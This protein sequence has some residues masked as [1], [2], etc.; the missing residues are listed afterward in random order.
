M[1]GG[2]RFD[3]GAGK[4][5]TVSGG[6]LVRGAGTTFALRTASGCPSYP[7]AAINVTGDPFAGET[8]YQ[9]V[10][11]FVDAHT[12]GMAFEFLGGSVHCGRPWHS[13]RRAVRPRGLPGPHAHPGQGRPA[14]VGAV[15]QGLARPGRLA[16]L[17]G[18]AGA[19]VTDPRGHLLPV[20]G[21]RLAWRAAGLREPAGREQ[22]GSA[23]LYPIKRNSCDDMD[24]IR[25]QASDMYKMQDYIDAQFGGPGKGFYRIVKDPFEARRV[26][27]G[28]KMA[29]VMGIETSIPFGC[30]YKKLA[31]QGLP[32]LHGGADR[33]QPRRDAEA[34]GPA[35]GAWSTSSTTPWPGSP[36]TRA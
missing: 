25:L 12:H 13:L 4:V 31:G 14:G 22:Q 35:D 32:R 24:S 26:V 15:R 8:T 19:G 36:A 9:E 23:S 18:L 10:R 30:T 28:G 2:F 7:E 21:A 5:L 20:A 1:T 16:D 6:K 11:G 29:V 27:N 33:R 17:Q 34:R 3:L